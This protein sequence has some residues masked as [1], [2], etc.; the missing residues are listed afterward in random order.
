MEFRSIIIHN[1]PVFPI[2]VIA[3]KHHGLIQYFSST[4]RCRAIASRGY[5]PQIKSISNNPFPS[6]LSIP[7]LQS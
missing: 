7:Q 4:P 2:Q 1:I 3:V 6:A 5:K